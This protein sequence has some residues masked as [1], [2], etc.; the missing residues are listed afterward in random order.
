MY[1]RSKYLNELLTKIWKELKIFTLC[2]Q[3]FSFTKDFDSSGG[4][5]MKFTASG[6]YRLLIEVRG[7]CK[8]MHY[9]T[10]R[11]SEYTEIT[12]NTYIL[13]LL[14]NMNMK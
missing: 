6:Y 7:K 4:R 14:S 10:L 11:Y 3:F 8:Y 2:T 9:L 13:S 5:V 1:I 12:F